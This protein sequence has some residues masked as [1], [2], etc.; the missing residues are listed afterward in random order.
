MQPSDAVALR[1]RSAE[2]LIQPVLDLPLPP[3]KHSSY[4][5]IHLKSLPVLEPVCCNLQKHRGFSEIPGINRK[6]ALDQGLVLNQAMPKPRLDASRR[7]ARVLNERRGCA[8]TERLPAR[9]CDPREGIE[10]G[11]FVWPY[12]PGRV[13]EVSGSAAVACPCTIATS[14]LDSERVG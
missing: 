5:S 9:M 8:L 2:Q 4:P 10:T 12:F 7:R 1:L 6:T 14:R 13:F 11:V 3:R